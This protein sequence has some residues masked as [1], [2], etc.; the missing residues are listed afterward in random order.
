MLDIKTLKKFYRLPFDAG[1]V[2]C[3]ITLT[4]LCCSFS[5]LFGEPAE[6]R[7]KSGDFSQTVV[8]TGNLQAREAEQ[9]VVPVTESWQI[10]LKWITKEGDYVMPGDP[11]VRFDTSTVT[12]DIENMELNLQDKLEQKKQKSADYSNQKLELELKVRQA[13][14]AY[15]EKELDA[16]IPKGIISDQ[17]YEQ[18]QLELKRSEEALK[19]AQTEKQVK[20][21]ALES[22]LQRLA[23]DI[24]EARVNLEKN[25]KTM[26]SLTVTATTAGAVVYA[27]HEWLGRKIQVGDNVFST[28]TVA[29]IPNINSLQAEAWVNETYIHQ[30]KPGQKVDIFPDAYPDKRFAGTIKYVLNTA[31]KRNR[32]G[33]AHYF[34]VIIIPD[35][36]DFN[37]MKPGMSVKCIAHTANIAKALL[38]A[39]EM[40]YFDGQIFLIKPKGKEILK[41][42]PLGFNEFYLA[43]SPDNNEKIKEGNLLEPVT[44]PDIAKIKE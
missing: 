4:F 2:F 36:L 19:N 1:P 30:I 37:I 8:L 10:Q 25:K 21:A 34:N 12:A 16:S 41:V 27:E 42:T 20:L 22:E 9:L 3:S 18:N 14:V 5:A 39:V 29:S 26:D 6:Y 28:W 11:V 17:K 35:T 43:L 44:P 24:Q 15:R 33:K 31:E 13:E 7:V 38:I 23:I 32:W 40:V